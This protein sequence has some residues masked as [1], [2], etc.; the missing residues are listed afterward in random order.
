MF[1]DYEG[2]NITNNLS[3]NKK[4]STDNQ[5]QTEIDEAEFFDEE[6]QVVQR[7]EGFTQT[8]LIEL[9]SKN[10]I[11]IDNS[12]LKVFLDKAINLIVDA[13]NIRT[14]EILESKII[15]NIFSC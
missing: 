7:E 12:K 9:N 14:D 13:L 2:K 10:N 11:V 15:L 5:A 6:V 1:N 3:K 8:N 4:S